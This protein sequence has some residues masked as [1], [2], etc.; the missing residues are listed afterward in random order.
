MLGPIERLIYKL[1]R[2]DPKREQTWIGYSVAVLLF[3]VVSLLVTYAML[4]LQDKL[5]GQHLLN[6]QGFAAPV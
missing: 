6:P 4:R 3:S 5:P 1:L 2:V